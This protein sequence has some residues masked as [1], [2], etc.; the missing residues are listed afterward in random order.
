MYAFLLR[1]LTGK[2]ELLAPSLVCKFE[3]VRNFLLEIRR[4][5]TDQGS[6]EPVF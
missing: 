5:R 2:W 4:L 6:C 1:Y 3:L